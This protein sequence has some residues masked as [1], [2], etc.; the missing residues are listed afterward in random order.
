V[1]RLKNQPVE[2]TGSSHESNQVIKTVYD[3][4]LNITIKKRGFDLSF[5]DFLD[6]DF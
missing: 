3:S 5:F 2:C 1:E 4:H 6:S